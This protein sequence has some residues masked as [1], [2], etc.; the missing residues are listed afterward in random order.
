L[1]YGKI[2]RCQAYY[3][4]TRERLESITLVL[5]LFLL[6]IFLLSGLRKTK[7]Y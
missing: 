1:P 7:K 2:A 6:L 5:L 4:K 3:S